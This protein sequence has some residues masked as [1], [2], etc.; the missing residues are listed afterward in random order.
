M[1]HPHADEM[2]QMAMGMMGFWVT[3]PKGKHPL[4][5]EVDRDF[6]FLLNAYDIDPG[7]T[8]PRS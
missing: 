3:H 5:D 2:V 8:R 4:I 7:S 6:C 1:Y